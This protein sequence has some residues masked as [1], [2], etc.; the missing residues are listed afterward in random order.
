M[1][2]LHRTRKKKNCIRKH[3]ANYLKEFSYLDEEDEAK[4]NKE[5]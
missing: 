3:N 2:R 4:Q 5:A 1:K